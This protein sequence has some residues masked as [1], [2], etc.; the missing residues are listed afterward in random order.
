MLNAYEQRLIA[1]YLSNAAS[2]LH[3][4]DR[5]ASDLAEWVTGRENRTELLSNLVYGGLFMRRLCC[6]R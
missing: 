5:E 6:P 3:H 1:F 2:S 4:R